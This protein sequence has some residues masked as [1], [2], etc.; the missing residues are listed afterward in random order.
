MITIV[1]IGV[2]NLGSIENMLK[3]IGC[4]PR[5]SADPEVILSASKIILPGVG[6]FDHGMRSLR[7]RNLEAVLGE[8]VLTHRTPVLGIC[9]GMQML[10]RSSEE[11]GEPGL[12]WIAACSR[13]FGGE[14]WDA[15]LKVPHMGWNAVRSQGDNPLLIGIDSP[16]YY[17]VHAYHF[18]CDDPVVA[19]GLTRY[20]TDFASMIHQENIFG[21]QFH[22]EKSHRFGFA[23]F[24]NFL[25]RC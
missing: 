8:K 2:G 22:P 23:L 18:V 14:G 19:S 20:G 17:F 21:V 24:R 6:S 1:D 15:H 5:I 4:T 9:L 3:K 16:R 12:G 10:G 11:G 13:R 7:E 25:E